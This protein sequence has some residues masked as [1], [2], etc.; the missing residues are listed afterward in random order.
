MSLLALVV[1]AAA[2]PFS[3]DVFVPLCDGRQLA[4]GHGGLGDPRS[5]EQNLYWGAAYGAERFLAPTRGYRV[6][7]R[8]DAPDPDRPFVLRELVLWRAPGNRERE[9]RLR[10]RAYAGDHIDDALHDFLTAAGSGEADVVVWAGHDRLMDVDQPKLLPGA[11]PR[12]AVVLACSSE[13]YFGPA[14]ARIGARPLL[15]TRTFMAPE[16]YLIDAVADAIARH[17]LDPAK[18]R[19]QA[20]SA[21]AKYQGISSRA[22]STVF[23]RP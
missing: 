20:I 19:A 1:M 16:A 23:A 10:L 21:Y 6:I 9:V 15:L 5:L 11:S 8:R 14:L 22:A 3:I 4:C 18:I 13:A 12:P 17:G 2:S 7:S